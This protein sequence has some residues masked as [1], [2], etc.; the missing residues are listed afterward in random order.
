[1]QRVAWNRANGPVLTAGMEFSRKSSRII[2]LATL[3]AAMRLPT[4]A[5]QN[6]A[7]PASNAAAPTILDRLNAMMAGGKSAWTPDQL[8]VME[9]LRDAAMNDPYAL[10]QLRHLT[11][12]IG[13]RISGSPQAAQAVE[14]VAA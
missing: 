14:Y 11:D 6:A 5:A 8:A 7:P 4:C 10:D 13:P 3:A 1:M 9:R 12:N 2:V